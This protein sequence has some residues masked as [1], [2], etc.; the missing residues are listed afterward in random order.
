MDFCGRAQCVS[1]RGWAY[2]LRLISRTRIRESSP[3]AHATALS[4]CGIRCIVSNIDFFS[5]GQVS[6]KGCL[7]LQTPDTEK[8]VTWNAIGGNAKCAGAGAE[9][10]EEL[11][12]IVAGPCG[13]GR[14][15]SLSL[16]VIRAGLGAIELSQV[17]YTH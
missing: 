2:L 12:V 4:I 11:F 5:R 1:V 13:A 10:I 14:D 16:L 9:I 7:Q 8:Y 17:S 15:T 6:V 3:R